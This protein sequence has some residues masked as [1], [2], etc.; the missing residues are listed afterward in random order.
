[1]QQI[2]DLG[3]AESLSGQQD[4]DDPHRHSPSTV[5]GGQQV[6]ALAC[7]DGR[8]EVDRAHTVV[9]SSGVCMVVGKP[10]AIPGEVFTLESPLSR[11][12]IVMGYEQNFRQ[13]A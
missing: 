10:H 3:R 2:G 1:V 4:H 9:A 13:P 7:R 11:R 8:V 6:L 12:V 5:H